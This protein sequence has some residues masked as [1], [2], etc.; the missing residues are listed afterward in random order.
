MKRNCCDNED[1]VESFILD[2]IVPIIT[3]ILFIGCVL[4]GV[5]MCFD[6]QYFWDLLYL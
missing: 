4:L 6:Y 1:F 2:R 5:G 3:A